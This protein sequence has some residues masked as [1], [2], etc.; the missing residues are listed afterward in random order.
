MKGMTNDE[1]PQGDLMED[2]DGDI[3]LSS[4]VEDG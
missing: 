2:I 3:E 4:T 1:I